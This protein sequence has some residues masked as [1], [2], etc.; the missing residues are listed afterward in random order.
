[1][2]SQFLDD[3]VESLTEDKL[4][5]IP[6]RVLVLAHLEDRDDVGMV[7]LRRG[8]RFTL[9]ALANGGV[10]NRVPKR[11]QGDATP[12]RQL[13]GLVNNAAHAAAADLTQDAI[14]AQ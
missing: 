2:L 6:A 7:Q 3:L 12:Q 9:E 14:I 8:A 11:L 4:H 1:L 13:L 10:N 5:G